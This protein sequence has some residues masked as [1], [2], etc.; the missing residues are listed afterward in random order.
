LSHLDGAAAS[1]GG[2][3]SPAGAADAEL[4]GL[5]GDLDAARAT[6]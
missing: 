6:L 4:V 3:R 5:H 2:G 1:E